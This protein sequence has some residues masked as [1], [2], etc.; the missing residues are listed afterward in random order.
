M[1]PV[2]LTIQAFGPFAGREVIDF[3]DAVAAGL[4]GIYGQTGAGKSTL[5]SA[6][7]FAL[8]GE[9]SKS[10]Q[11]APSLRSDHA[12][13]GA[14][15]EVEFVF[16][17]GGQR[18]VV[19]RRP[20]QMRP[21]QRGEG[22][23]RSPHEAHLFNATGMAP[24]TIT[25]DTRG[26]IIAE[27]KVRE[28]DTAITDLLG[29][30]P[31]QF[32]Q[33]VLLPQ[34]RFETFLSAKTRDRLEILR[35]LFDV[36]LY[37]S[38]MAELKSEAE[39]AERHVREERTLC[40]RQLAA[41]GFES[42]E[43]LHAGIEDAEV[44]LAQQLAHEAQ[45]RAAC[46]AAQAALKAA[47]SIE[48]RFAHAEAAAT[49]L[50]TLQAATV[51][52]DALAQRVTQAAR[53]QTLL[54]TERYAD[55]AA[56][57]VAAAN[58]TLRAAQAADA[59][60]QDAS[61]AAANELSTIMER[62]GELDAL[63]RKLD[64]FERHAEALHKA[65][66]ISD[67][68]AAA[69]TAER[70]ANQAHLTTQQQLTALLET[71]RARAEELKT[72][73]QTEGQRHA[74]AARRAS[75][76]A[77]LTA[78][79]SYEKAAQDV[80]SAQASHA[81]HTATLEAATQR[82]E[83]A[84]AGF[85]QAERALTAA[86]AYH[87]AAKLAPG[88]PCPVCGATDHPAPATATQEHAGL[89]QAFRTAKTAWQSA[90]STARAAAEALAGT[91]STL[92][93]RK[94]RLALLV[95]PD[96]SSAALADKIAAEV[97]ALDA[98][99]PETDIA[100]AEAAIDQL[101]AEIAATEAR[102]DAQRD[103]VAQSQQETA[104]VTARRDEMLSSVPDD[105]RDPDALTA[106]RATATKALADAEAQRTAAETAARASREA[107]IAAHKEHEA[108]AAALA[109][110]TQRHQTAVA[111]LKDRLERAGLSEAEFRA[112]KPAIETLEADRRTVEDHRRK[113]GIATEA[114]DTAAAAVDGL[115]RPD[116]AY[117]SAQLDTATDTQ[118]AATEQRILA[119]SR[120]DHL[121]RLQGNLADT[122][123]R[124]D[125]AETASGPLRLLAALVNGTN[126]QKLDLETFA[127]GTM[128]D[129]VLEAAN[130]RLGPMTSGRYR[131][132]RDGEGAGRGR[133]GLGIQVF[134][135]FTGK[136]RPTTTLSGGESFI[137]ALALALGLADVVESAS[138]KVRLDTIFI[139]E[140]FGSLDTE[141]GSGT[142]DQVL[143]VLNALV[144]QNRAVGLIS[145]V[146]LVQEAIPNGFYIRK[147]L[148]GSHVEARGP[149]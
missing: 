5:F 115:T 103:A 68:V 10:E 4:F 139:D 86:Q 43:A 8:F 37:Q 16:D 39:T 149:G 87:L 17:V 63:R 85:Q 140:G 134:D 84:L 118:S 3:R 62:A 93:E 7:T 9:P 80:Q 119:T 57:D 46:E 107:A 105:L 58:E 100:A 31:E 147:G 102:R 6:M 138:G 73:R 59:R 135:L 22:E 83:A 113:L 50:A 101:D 145:H 74:T 47:E 75:L 88:A 55:D 79:Q 72:A 26:K 126:A 111:A 35:E 12:D 146:P 94:G 110:C 120:R 142:L 71:R 136:S 95:P 89:D 28:V 98:L 117:L 92:R 33:I 20:E 76:A 127:I 81:A 34:G 65:A 2:R 123:R 148:S 19:W 109:T 14:Q 70:Q 114:A 44:Q 90:D 45:A 56:R 53:A 122:L 67:M 25:D 40:A 38:L 66:D 82:A 29:Y 11:E 32:R 116:L 125:E 108:A 30:G 144:S 54:D 60:A 124:L 41:E 132:E 106:A 99:G 51:K 112:L 42:T 128:F 64:A 69:A 130:L 121:T 24:D 78:A 143:Q 104:R 52:M 91:T 49:E 141:N 13:P 18:F 48:A 131:L 1:R 97:Q 27:K 77:A 137:A 36:S 133:R 61:R 21:K 15:T 129:R 23:T 96:E